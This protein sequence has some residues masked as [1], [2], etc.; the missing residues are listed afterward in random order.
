MRYGEGIRRF[1]IKLLGGY[2][3]KI[4]KIKYEG[5]EIIIEIKKIFLKRRRKCVFRFKGFKKC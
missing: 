5:E 4:R 1:N 2:L 3:S